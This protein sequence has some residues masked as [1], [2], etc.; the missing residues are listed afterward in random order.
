MWKENS[1]DELLALANEET[2]ASVREEC[3]RRIMPQTKL[4][5]L[6]V[7]ICDHCNLNCRG[8]DH[9]SPIADARFLDPKNIKKDLSQM[10]KILNEDVEL[11]SVMGG[12]PLL[13]PQL[14]EIL[15]A[16]REV[17]PHTDIWLSTNG[18]LLLKQTDEFWNCCKKMKLKYV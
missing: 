18:I 9:F 11:V 13:H 10:R 2:E 7:N 12:E 14:D 6:I 17:F 3:I 8:C 1:Y 15:D 5:A 4:K 16:A